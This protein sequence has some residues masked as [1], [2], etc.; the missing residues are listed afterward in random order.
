MGRPVADEMYIVPD[1]IY[2]RI[3]TY[4]KMVTHANIYE[5]DLAPAPL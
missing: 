1:G 5:M 3:G 2:V 4:E